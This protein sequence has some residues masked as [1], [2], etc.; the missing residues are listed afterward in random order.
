LL[1][2]YMKFFSP[3]FSFST[4][5]FYCLRSVISITYYSVKSV[6]TCSTH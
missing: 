3:H 1:L 4:M 2:Q 6:L 5:K